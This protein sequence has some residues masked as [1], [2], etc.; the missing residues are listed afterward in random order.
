MS[1]EV[2]LDYFQTTLDHAGQ[3]ALYDFLVKKAAQGFTKTDFIAD[4]TD[5]RVDEL[6]W[7]ADSHCLTGTIFRIRTDDLPSR[8]GPQDTRKLA[9]REDE[10]LGEGT[11]FAL[12]PLSGVVA[13]HYNHSGARH[14]KLPAAVDALGYAAPFGL[15]PLFRKDTIKRLRDANV[16]RKVRYRLDSISQYK[17]AVRPPASVSGGI[18]AATHLQGIS[19]A[20]EVTMSSV[21]GSLEK[22]NVLELV[23]NLLQRPHTKVSVHIRDLEESELVA[24]NLL[25][26]R[27]KEYIEIGLVDR[28]LNRDE[29]QRKLRGRAIFI[30][31]DH[32]LLRVP[33][34]P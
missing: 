19:V 31:N 26:D 27:E 8:V 6:V 9:L 4:S 14:S 5:Y 13:V 32:G 25:H 3:D 33:V 1:K 11:C 15:S 30:A 23:S 20:V 28:E 16:I 34:K 29:C 10:S 7:W 12:L 2:R 24:L 22:K 18:D 21:P 17:D